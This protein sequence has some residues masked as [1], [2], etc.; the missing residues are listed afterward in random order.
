MPWL[1]VLDNAD[2]DILEAEEYF[3][4]ED[5]GRVIITIRLQSLKSKESTAWKSYCLHEL[6][7]AESIQLLLKST[8]RRSP[9]SKTDIEAVSRICADLGNIPLALT[10]VGAHIATGSTDLEPY[11]ESYQ[12]PKLV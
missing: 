9:F 1:S 10:Q 6:F 7:F 5:F 8:D 12:K 3:P 4:S 2:D 11:L